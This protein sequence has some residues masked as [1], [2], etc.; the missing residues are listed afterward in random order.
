M[1]AVWTPL[2]PEYNKEMTYRV[3]CFQLHSERKP[4][5]TFSLSP[6]V[7]CL[8]FCSFGYAVCL[9]LF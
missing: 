7:V 6:I 9:I 5:W 4:K 8:A 2:P 3:A 1:I